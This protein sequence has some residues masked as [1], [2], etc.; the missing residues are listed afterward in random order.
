MGDLLKKAIVEAESG[1]KMDGKTDVYIGARFDHISATVKNSDVAHDKMSDAL[2]NRRKEDGKK[3]DA[4]QARID[5]M[6]K[7]SDRWKQPVGRTKEGFSKA[8]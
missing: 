1:D 6:K 3:V 7:D 2:S 8:N 4:K 5:R